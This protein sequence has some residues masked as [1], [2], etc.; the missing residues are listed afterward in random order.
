VYE[1]SDCGY[2]IYEGQKFFDSP[3]GYICED[4]IKDM[5][6]IEFMELMGEKLTTAERED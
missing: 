3:R 6:A 1:C 2:G 5:S 4:C